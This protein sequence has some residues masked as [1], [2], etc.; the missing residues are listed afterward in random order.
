MLDGGVNHDTTTVGLDNVAVA[1]G[2]FEEHQ[3]APAFAQG[4]DEKRMSE[5]LHHLRDGS[6]YQRM[7][8]GNRIIRFATR[9]IRFATWSRPTNN[10]EHRQ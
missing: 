5:L 1:A 2:V 4:L 10:R 7:Y 6:T 3:F 8:D 9:I